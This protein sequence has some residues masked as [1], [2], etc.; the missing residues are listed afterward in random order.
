MKTFRIDSGTAV[1]SDPCYTPGTWCAA[2]LSDCATGEWMAGIALSDEDWWGIRVSELLA[3]SSKVSPESPWEEHSD[4]GV[5][6]GQM[7]IFERNDYRGGD[8][9][10]WYDAICKGHPVDGNHKS[11]DPDNHLYT[12]PD[13]RGVACSTGFGDGVYPLRVRYGTD[14]AGN[15]VICAMSVTFIGEEEED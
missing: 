4:L 15:R 6:S 2:E 11:E 13:R 12:H 9:G 5:D 8:H 14:A 3:V 7:S 10:S 1:V